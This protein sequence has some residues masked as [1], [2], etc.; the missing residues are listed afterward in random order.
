MLSS[1]LSPWYG[2]GVLS[3]HPCVSVCVSF[4]P[5]PHPDN[6]TVVCQVLEKPVFGVEQTLP[7]TP[8]T[9]SR[10][11]SITQTQADTPQKP[12]TPFLWKMCVMEASVCSIQKA[13][14]QAGIVPW[15]ETSRLMTI[16]DS[17]KSPG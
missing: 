4:L 16:P 14:K 11:D 8:G 15:L 1:V 9:R 5:L 6:S 2:H 3:H 13:S 10:P 17:L 7:L 12:E